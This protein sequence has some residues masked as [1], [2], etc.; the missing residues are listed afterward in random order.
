MKPRT[1]AAFAIL[2]LAGGFAPAYAAGPKPGAYGPPNSVLFER[3]GS[4]VKMRIH[5]APANG[6]ASHRTLLVPPG[7]E[8]KLR[9]AAA[10]GALNMAQNEQG[11][12]F[13]VFGGQTLSDAVIIQTRQG[14]YIGRTRLQLGA[15]PGHWIGRTSGLAKSS[16]AQVFDGA[17]LATT[18]VVPSQSGPG[19]WIRKPALRRYELSALPS[20]TTAIRIVGL[21]DRVAP[22]KSKGPKKTPKYAKEGGTLLFTTAEGTLRN[23]PY[24]AS[25]HEYRVYATKAVDR[26]LGQLGMRRELK[27]E[28]RKVLF[29]AMSRYGA[30][31]KIK[32]DGRIIGRDSAGYTTT[33]SIGAGGQPK[34]VRRVTAKDG[35][36][37]GGDYGSTETWHQQE[38]PSGWE[39]VKK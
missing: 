16:K 3:T 9:A 7:V 1:T 34:I 19:D 23:S 30:E 18:S 5:H 17:T 39:L 6:K 15:N 31:V 25:K 2:C 35:A 14:E 10:N 27:E 13:T 28:A 4:A 20:E 8:A 12:G 24:S 38:G 11:G 33:I 36:Y 22:T 37:G 29:W 21:A 26:A 32:P